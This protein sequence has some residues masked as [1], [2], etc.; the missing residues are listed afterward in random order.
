MEYNKE[1]IDK[2]FHE[3][4]QSKEIAIEE[5]PCIDL[6]MDQVTTFFEDKLSNSKR[7]PED[8]ILTKTMINNYTKGKIL[9]PAKKKK[10]TT[11]HMI[12]LILI[13]NLKQGLSINDINTLFNSIF[14]EKAEEIKRDVHIDEV[15][16]SF[17][18]IKTKE[19]EE[20]ENNFN[21]MIETIEEELMNL[22]GEEKDLIQVFI[23]VLVLIDRANSY[24]RMA[25]KV[26]DNFVKD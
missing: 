6:Y 24:R 2:L 20:L 11:E 25:E 15:Y 13:Y 10:Y 8:K 18:C 23:T 19:N 17:L 3:I 26:I 1:N 14:D 16:K 4:V 9:M 5:I 7:N 22:Q 21:A 12:L